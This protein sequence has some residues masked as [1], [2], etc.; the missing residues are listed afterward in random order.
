M[1]EYFF[2]LLFRVAL[3]PVRYALGANA[4]NECR[5]SR[6][7]L[8]LDDRP[9]Q[10]PSPL[11]SQ[12]GTLSHFFGALLG[13]R[14]V[15]PPGFPIHPKWTTCCKLSPQ[16]RADPM[17]GAW[18]DSGLVIPWRTYGTHCAACKGV[19]ETLVRHG[20]SGGLLML[21]YINRTICACLAN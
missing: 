11:R 15:A 2:A 8:Q 13:N 16:C 4:I 21:F 9:S 12:L 14:E 19:A 5:L 17:T 1:V 6:C 7:Q 20:E 18:S 10:C 3:D